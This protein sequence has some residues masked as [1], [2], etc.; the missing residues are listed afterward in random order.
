[1]RGIFK[2]GTIFALLIVWIGGGSS[3]C[4]AQN[5]D[6]YGKGS[7]LFE[8]CQAYVR[9]IDNPNGG[10]DSDL[11]MGARCF[12]YLKGFTDGA[13]G[14]SQIKP[15]CP[16]D[17]STGTTVRIYVKYMQ[18][19]PKL[20]DDAKIVGLLAAWKDAYPCRKGSAPEHDAKSH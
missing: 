1:M 17:A 15:F 11:N 5:T 2:N 8:K 19:H 12:D 18:D 6:E 3:S 20:L 10:T 4:H 13:M 14:F 7:W 9:M 16:G